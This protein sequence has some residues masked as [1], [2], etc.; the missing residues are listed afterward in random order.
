MLNRLCAVFSIALRIG[1]VI[2]AQ[3]TAV[4]SE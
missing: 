2:C 3:P 4:P 1:G